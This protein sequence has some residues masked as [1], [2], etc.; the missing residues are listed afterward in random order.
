MVDSVEDGEEDQAGRADEGAED[1]QAGQNLLTS[2]LIAH[3]SASVSEIALRQEGEV[4]GDGGDGGAGDEEWLH[5]IGA[6]VADVG[7]RHV[8]VNGRIPLAVCADDPVEQHAQECSQ[9]DE[10]REDGKPLSNVGFSADSSNRTRSRS[11]RS[12]TYPI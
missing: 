6:N 7:E 5:L 4:K 8:G 1:G 2:A 11:G 12:G 10:A 3:Q 9:P